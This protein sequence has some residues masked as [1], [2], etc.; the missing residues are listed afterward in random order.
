M[1]AKLH[2]SDTLVRSAV[3]AF[4]WRTV[5]WQ[6]VL[7]FFLVAGG[8]GYMLLKGDRSWLIGVLGVVLVLSFAFVVALYLVHLRSSLERFQRMKVKEA[9]LDADSD[10]VVMTSDVGAFELH[11]SAVRD[12]WRFERFWLLFVSR[13]QFVTLPV[14]DL[15]SDAQE[16]I[17][18][19]V[20]NH[21][22]KVA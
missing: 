20:R 10:K 14:A 22:G 3:A 15:P 9:T 11:W 7:A 19:R 18:E 5:G 2:Y 12:V 8:L 17:M 13:A 16:F 1:Q 4:W 6:F 21:G